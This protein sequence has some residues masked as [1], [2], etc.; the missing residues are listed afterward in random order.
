MKTLML[1]INTA[2][3]AVKAAYAALRCVLAT[4]RNTR[5]VVRYNSGIDVRVSLDLYRG[6]VGIVAAC[7][8]RAAA[9]ALNAGETAYRAGV[10]HATVYASFCAG[11]AAHDAASRLLLR[12]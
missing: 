7:A 4:P 11:D 1:L 9:A 2:S 8:Y 10:R 3:A 12:D 5:Q 6:V